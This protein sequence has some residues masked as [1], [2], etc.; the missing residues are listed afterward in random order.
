MKGYEA[1]LDVLPERIRRAAALLGG[2]ERERATEFRLRCGESLTVFLPEGEQPVGGVIVC[3]EDIERLLEICSGASPYAAAES[4]RNGF[5]TVSGG[6]RVGFCGQ[7]VSEGGVVRTLKG[8]SSAAVRIPRE[9]WGCGA[10]LCGESFVSTLILSPPGG[11]KTTL[12][13]DM[14]RCLSRSGK[15]VALCDE[16]GEVAALSGG[17]PGFDLGPSTDVLSGGRKSETAMMLLRSMAPDIV[18][19]DEITAAED[20]EACQMLCHC[21]VEMLATAHASSV[22]EL[23]RRPLYRE[24][25]ERRIFRRA[26]VIV[27]RGT[28]RIYR[29]ERLC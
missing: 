23:G 16:R 17:R 24:L 1:A 19:M 11:G 20:I 27:R 9:V 3:R 26:V 12:L 10:A 13:R 5:I 7:V 22:A 28:E 4:L 25:L 6:V 2:K 14:I 18:A 8:F 21:G 29:E 15:R